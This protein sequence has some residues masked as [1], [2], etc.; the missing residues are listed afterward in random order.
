[1]K[2]AIV[3]DELVRKG[4]GEQVTLSFHHAF[5]EAPIYTLSYNAE[6]TFPEFKECTI[7]T[8]SFG[9]LIKDDVNLRRFFFPFGIWSMQRL[10]LEEFDVV[11]MSTTHCAKYVRVSKKAL[12][13]TYCHTPFRLAW[14]GATY[15]AVS[16]AKGL[17]KWAYNRV[18][19]YLQKV[20]KASA[21]KT[22]WFITNSSEV[23][24]RIMKVY[25][26]KQPVTII[27]PSVKCSYFHTAEK[28]INTREGYYLVVSRFE[29]YKKVDL[30]IEAFNQMPGKKLVIV[31]KGSLEKKCKELAAG[32]ENIEFKNGVSAETLANLYANCNALIF[33]QHEDYGITPLE[34]NASGRPVIAYGKGGV[35][36]TMKPYTGDAQKATAL[37][38]DEQD[39]AHLIKAVETFET[40]NF[41]PSFIRAHAE[42]FDE[43]KFVTAIQSF[44]EEKHRAFIRSKN[45]VEVKAESIRTGAP[46]AS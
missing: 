21:A 43:Q 17:K 24:P 1:M 20:D 5:P 12:V 37:F 23:L 4:G 8:S 11:L 9:K 10:N 30:V 35:L 13:I 15:S 39:T 31:G 19:S 41:N 7:R 44:V 40:L 16:E 2:I 45:A 6:R 33:P 34:A 42:Q 38:F 28:E 22:H 46:V 18:I 14:D 29:P 3:Q 26:P 36:D 25:Q 27:N 32:N